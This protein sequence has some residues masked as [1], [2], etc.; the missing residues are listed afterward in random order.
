MDWQKAQKEMK[1]GLWVRHAFFMNEEAITDQGGSILFDDGYSCTYDQFGKY[2][3]RN[4][5][6]I[7]AWTETG[8]QI[9]D[10][11][12]NLIKCK[13]CGIWTTD[14]ENQCYAANNCSKNE[15]QN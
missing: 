11:P 10:A 4:S 1:N 7:Q 5:R 15:S 12:K 13:H 3:F 2:R 9:T 14:P 8:W 6:S